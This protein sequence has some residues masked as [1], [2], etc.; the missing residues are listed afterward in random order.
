MKAAFLVGPQ[1]F[2]IR[3]IPDPE[4]PHD[5][6][7]M[8]IK[9]C[10][11]CGSDLRRWREGLP[12]GREP[13][14]SGHEFAG[15]VT[16]VGPD[17]H[18]YKVG[19]L[20][21]VAADVHCGKCY[22]CQRGM[23]N[24]CESAQLVGISAGMP[25]GLGEKAALSGHILTNGIVHRMPDGMSFEHAAL[26]EPLS[27]VLAAHHK[28]QTNIS[29]TVVVLGGGPIGCL[30]IAVAH[31]RGAKV[32]LSEPS[33]ERREM[34]APFQPDAVIDPF[35]EDVI[36]RVRELTGGLGA[37]I[38]VCANPIAATQTQ[39]IE[40][41]RKGGRV[42]L[43][44]GLPK[45]NKMVSFDSNRIHYDEIEVVGAFSYH[46]IFH[47]QALDVLQRGL[48]DGNIVITHIFSLDEV[49]Q[50][51]QASANGQALKAIVKP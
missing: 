29:H 48:I 30:H 28:A 6:L 33:A 32:I 3:Q 13:Y 15:V 38:V 36:V 10:G 19:D 11:V 27:S 4:V 44:G 35:K 39:A 51:F 20:L 18:D 5:G 12:A 26:A 25:G 43:F 1:Q 9:A 22:Y 50:A 45:A 40:M 49:D 17:Q 34:A 7:V 23:F 46:P 24:L 37:D 31:A 2:E 47:E 21:A 16:A 42:V 8:D 14:I 41:V